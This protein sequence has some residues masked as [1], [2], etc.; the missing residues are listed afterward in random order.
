MKVVPRE[1]VL[2]E[3]ADGRCPFVEWL[4]G[5]KDRRTRAI[6]DARLLRLEHGN[7]GDSRPVGDG[8]ME[9]R[10]HAGPGYR[11][12]FGQDG[13]TI[14]VLLCGGDKGSQAQDIAAAKSYWNDYRS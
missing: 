9:L 12:Y 5:L 13:E 3:T 11:V 1:L 8:V 4:D 2:Y 6:I 7:L 14:V 10:V